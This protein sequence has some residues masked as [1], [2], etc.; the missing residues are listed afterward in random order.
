MPQRVGVDPIFNYAWRVWQDNI[1]LLAG[2]TFVYLLITVPI[3]AGGEA[4]ENV[5]R[6]EGERGAAALV[7][8]IGSL[9]SFF[10]QTFLGIG[11]ATIALKLV[12]G[13]RAEF[14]DLFSGANRY[15]PLLIANFLFGIVGAF[16]FLLCIVPFVILFLMFWPYYWLLVDN[17]ASL[18]DSP[19]LASKVTEGNWGT[20]FLLFLLSIVVGIVG[21]LACGIGIIFAIPLV[22]LL[23]ATAYLMMSGQ[24][25]AYPGYGPQ[26]VQPAFSPPGGSPFAGK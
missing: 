20:A 1:G 16:A 14:G 5:L 23:W 26:P 2:T 10:M 22:T 11:Q 24:L 21:F 8:L 18:S 19:G 15:L 12:R 9:L 3:D 17:R 13:Q 6:E 25:A 7:G 4:L